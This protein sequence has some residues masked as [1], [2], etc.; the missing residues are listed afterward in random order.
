[1][2]CATK[3]LCYQ[4]SDPNIEVHYGTFFINPRILQ[5]DIRGNERQPRCE[6]ERSARI[7]M[8]RDPYYTLN[9]TTFDI[10]TEELLPF[11]MS[12]GCSSLVL[13]SSRI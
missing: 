4:C 7:Q 1:M 13:L 3:N 9:V 11:G 8:C 2:L 10:K 6:S 5:D 12:H